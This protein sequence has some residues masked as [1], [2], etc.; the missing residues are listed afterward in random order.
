MAVFIDLAG[1]ACSGEEKHSSADASYDHQHKSVGQVYA[2]LDAP[3]CSPTAKRIDDQPIFPDLF[4][5]TQGDAQRDGADD[6][7]QQPSRTTGAQQQAQR[8]G[9]QGQCDLQSWQ[10]A[11]NHNDSSCR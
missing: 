5:Q 10:L 3:R 9:N 8:R 6:Q 4:E 7:T 2:V 11:E 1:C